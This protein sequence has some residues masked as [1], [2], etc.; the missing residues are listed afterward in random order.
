M[1]SQKLKLKFSFTTQPFKD[2]LHGSDE[3]VMLK[4]PEALKRV[5][6]A[7]ENAILNGD[8]DREKLVQLKD[9]L[10]R[11]AN[12]PGTKIQ[13]KPVY[14]KVQ[15]DLWELAKVTLLVKWGGEVSMS[16]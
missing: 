15:D 8:G 6:D 16:Y 5:M 2:L 13:V 11:K 9:I 4:S 3:E 10:R 1:L 12:L 14:K 7:T